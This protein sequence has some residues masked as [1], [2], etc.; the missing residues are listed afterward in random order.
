MWWLFLLERCCARICF[1]GGGSG[2]SGYRGE[3]AWWLMRF[4]VD[5]VLQDGSLAGGKFQGS[6]V[7]L[8]EGDVFAWPPSNL[9]I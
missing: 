3:R 9:H 8:R 2:P 7:W 1:T 4:C 5:L 6:L